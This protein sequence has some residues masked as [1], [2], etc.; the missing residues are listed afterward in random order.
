MKYRKE[1]WG[2]HRLNLVSDTLTVRFFS[3]LHSNLLYSTGAHQRDLVQIFRIDWISLATQNRNTLISQVLKNDWSLF[4]SCGGSTVEG[5]LGR[6]ER[7]KVIQTLSRS[8]FWHPKVW[9]SSHRVQNFWCKCSIAM[10]SSVAKRSK[11]GRRYSLSLL[12]RLGQ[13]PIYSVYVSFTRIES[14][15]TKVPGCLWNVAFYSVW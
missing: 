8:P 13:P 11:R 3:I 12:K 5:N 7:Y 4:Q 10:M 14:Y 15:L 6:S 9:H 1:V 2:R